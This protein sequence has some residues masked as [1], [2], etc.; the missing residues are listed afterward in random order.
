MGKYE[1]GYWGKINYWSNTL[2]EA[3]DRKDIEMVKKV[4]DSKPLTELIQK[5]IKDKGQRLQ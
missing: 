4:A 5:S 1:N 3:V 2:K